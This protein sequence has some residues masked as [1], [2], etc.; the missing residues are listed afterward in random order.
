M[1][2]VVVVVVTWLAVMLGLAQHPAAQSAAKPRFEVASVKPSATDPLALPRSSPPSPGRLTLL[3]IPLR[4]LIQTAYGYVFNDF[5]IIGGPDWQNSR[6]FDIQAKAEDAGASRDAML[7]MLKTLLEER[8]QLKAHTETREMPIFA[9]VL[10]RP[11]NDDR[12]VRLVL[13]LRV[14][15]RPIAQ[16]NEFWRARARRPPDHSIS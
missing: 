7:P 8:F 10:A 16:L 6:R 13:Q 12:R 2:R 1:K 11:G 5:Q 3:D 15:A 4:L 9:L 14:R